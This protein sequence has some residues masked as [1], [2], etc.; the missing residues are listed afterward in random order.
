M[1]TFEKFDE[2]EVVFF[3][4]WLKKKDVDVEWEVREK[5]LFMEK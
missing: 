4:V 5:V 1:K 3:C 2:D